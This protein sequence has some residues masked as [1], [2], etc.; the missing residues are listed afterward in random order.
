[1]GYTP[2]LQGKTIRRSYRQLS[3]LYAGVTGQKHT[4]ELQAKR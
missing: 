1:M 2:E 3:Y 4:L